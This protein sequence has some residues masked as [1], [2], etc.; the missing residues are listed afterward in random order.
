ML[1]LRK[2]TTG[3][4]FN[5]ARGTMEIFNKTTQRIVAWIRGGYKSSQEDG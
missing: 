5:S 2:S 4:K 3:N 1:I